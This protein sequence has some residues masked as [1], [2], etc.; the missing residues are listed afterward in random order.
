[1]MIVANMTDIDKLTPSCPCS[2]DS[3]QTDKRFQKVTFGSG[4]CYSTSF[5]AVN[6]KGN[7]VGYDKIGFT[8][9]S[10]T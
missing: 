9:S 3:A 10:S 5:P 1:M 6:N 7:R 2:A 4:L 8:N